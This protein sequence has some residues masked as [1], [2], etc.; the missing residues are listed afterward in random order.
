MTIRI[1][2]LVIILTLLAGC[3]AQQEYPAKNASPLP[4]QADREKSSTPSPVSPHKY[5]PGYEDKEPKAK[6]PEDARHP[7][8]RI[9]AVFVNGSNICIIDGREFAMEGKA[10]IKKNEILLPFKYIAVALGVSDDYSFDQDKELITLRYRGKYYLFGGN[11]DKDGVLYTRL[12]NNLDNMGFAVLW[13][14]H[15]GRFEILDPLPLTAEDQEIGELYLSM[16]I[17]KLLAALG[18]PK[19]KD[20]SHSY[21]F[22]PDYTFISVSTDGQPHTIMVRSDRIATPRGIRV[23]DS[24]SKVFEA[25]GRGYTRGIGYGQPDVFEYHFPKSVRKEGYLSFEVDENNRVKE[26][27]INGIS[28]PHYQVTR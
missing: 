14:H 21:S 2:P 1:L 22:Y 18:P 7:D 27:V 6:V 11:L 9:I 19:N 25:Y 4:S 16:T 5:V 17:D 3:Y 10:T 26:I 15:A 28:L 12:V 8:Q 13:D 23:G 20:A 24:L